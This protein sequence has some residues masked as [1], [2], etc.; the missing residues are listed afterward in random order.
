MYVR[1]LQNFCR[2][3][4]NSAIGVKAIIVGAV[5]V[6][7][8]SRSAFSMLEHFVGHRNGSGSGLLNSCWEQVLLSLRELVVK[9]G[10]ME[11][12]LHPLTNRGGKWPLIFFAELVNTD[13][14]V[15]VFKARRRPCYSGITLGLKPKSRAHILALPSLLSPLGRLILQVR[16][17]FW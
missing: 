14:L 6:G 17:P 3:Y 10:L 15:C 13:V 11:A 2:F 7:E 12:H 5:G 9:E 16:L 4:P 8:A 1:F